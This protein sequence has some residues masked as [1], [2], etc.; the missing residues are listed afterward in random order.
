LKVIGKPDFL[1]LYYKQFKPYLRGIDISKWNN[2]NLYLLTPEEMPNTS[3]N[4][5]RPHFQPPNTIRIPIVNIEGIDIKIVFDSNI[6]LI[7]HEIGHFIHTTY[8]PNEKIDDPLW[9][10]W[11]ILT[12]NK[13]DFT[14]KTTNFG[15]SRHLYPHVPSFEDFA[16]NFKDWLLGKCVYMEKFF[17]SLWK[18]NAKINEEQI[19]IFKGILNHTGNIGK[20]KLFEELEKY[21]P[22]AL[23]YLQ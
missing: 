22:R 16:D 15:G 10:K 6:H 5:T 7:A 21:N 14:W 13:L 23:V 18:Q 9:K 20:I 12:G 11:A 2:L 3:L 19:N 1:N 8:L 17:M 4:S